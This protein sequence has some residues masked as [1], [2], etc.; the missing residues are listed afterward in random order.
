MLKT[1]MNCVNMVLVLIEEIYN[2]SDQ[3]RNA[4]ETNKK[5][6][7]MQTRD[8]RKLGIVAEYF[9][10]VIKTVNNTN[11]MK[12]LVRM[13]V[14]TELT[15][16]YPNVFMYI[17]AFIDML[18]LHLDVY[19]SVKG[20]CLCYL[21]GFLLRTFRIPV[22]ND[23][24][25]LVNSLFTLVFRNYIIKGIAFVAVA[26]IIKNP[27]YILKYAVTGFSLYILSLIYNAFVMVFS[28]SKYGVPF[29]DIDRIF[30]S[31]F[32]KEY[33]NSYTSK[34]ELMRDYCNYISSR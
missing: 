19:D 10:P 5:Y 9:L 23:I 6:T 24:V 31:I 34:K 20:L 11:G 7:A 29:N 16:L 25:L 1:C 30:F 15:Y 14:K 2:M 17:F 8:G 32:Y 12:E 18:F 26:L 28:N 21:A 27:M 13:L 22:V 3:Y 4:T 33:G